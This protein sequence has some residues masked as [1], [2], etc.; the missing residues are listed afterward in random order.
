MAVA[1]QILPESAKARIDGLAGVV[2]CLGSGGLADGFGRKSRI[3]LGDEEGAES[4]G[5]V[6]GV[7]V[8]LR[9]AGRVWRGRSIVSGLG[10]SMDP[11]T[12]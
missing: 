12:I 8:C 9:V 7:Y 1:S 5:T 11:L 4:E 3:F 6:G 2:A 10:I